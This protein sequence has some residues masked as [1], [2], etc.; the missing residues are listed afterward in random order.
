MSKQIDLSKRLSEEDREYLI[1]RGRL[2]D[3]RGN[4]EQFGDGPRS[5]EKIDDGNT[6]DVNP[7]EKDD[8][9]DLLAYRNLGETGVSV[10]QAV[11]SARNAGMGDDEIEE[12]VQSALRFAPGSDDPNRAA[13][14]QDSE[15]TRDY[16]QPYED[17]TKADLEKEIEERNAQKGEGEDKIS[18][19]GNKSDLA[20]RLD[21]DD[22]A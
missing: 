20:A 8:G 2:D 18:K 19:S 22:E 21:E 9:S 1:S 7:F 4:D 12:R 13:Q 11:T 16:D 6:G 15:D 10:V 5:L 3:V 17:W 14:E